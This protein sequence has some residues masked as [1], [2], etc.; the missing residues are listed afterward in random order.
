MSTLLLYALSLCWDASPS[1]EVD[2]YKVYVDGSYKE[3]VTRTTATVAGLEPGKV[4]GFTVTA[5]DDDAAL[6]SEPS[7]ELRFV[8]PILTIS[9]DLVVSFQVPH[10]SKQANVQYVLESTAD[11]K[12]WRIESYLVFNEEGRLY[13]GPPEPYRFYRVRLEI[14]DEGCSA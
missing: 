2:R 8:T 12:D 1:L 11:F 10:I 14:K 7:N 3:S 13:I 6:E 5:V 9:P 4:Y